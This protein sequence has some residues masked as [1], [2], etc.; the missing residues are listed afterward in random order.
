ME[1]WEEQ[2]VRELQRDRG[3]RPTAGAT[4]DSGPPP[5]A[6]L[7]GEAF[8]DVSQRVGRSA[9]RIAEAAGRTLEAG[10]ESDPPRRQWSVGTRRLRLRL[11]R[12]ATKFFISLESEAGLEMCE[13]WVEEGR[14]MTDADGPA[15][16]ADADRIV[17][18]YVSL[19]FRG[20]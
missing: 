17:Q 19:L 3:S 5:A 2:L 7:L 8:T 4:G 11:D 15:R 1:S 6:D 12:E 14:L 9:E 13:L 18:R 20:A 16:P 10:E